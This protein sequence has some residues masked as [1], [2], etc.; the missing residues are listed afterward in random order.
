M[1]EKSLVAVVAGARPNFMKIAPLIKE[2]KNKQINYK[3]IH[4]GQHYDFAMSKVFFQDLEIDDPDIFLN[5]GS[6]SHAVQTAKIMIA[7]EKW[8]IQNNPIL[9]IVVGDVNSTIACAL[10]AKKLFIKV[11]HIESGLRSFDF[12]MPEEINRILTDH[13]S[14]FLFITEKSA[15]NNLLKEGIDKKKIHFTG[16]IMIDSLT[17]NLNKARNLK[18]YKK[19][20]LIKNEFALVTLHRPSNVDNIENLK[21]I[22]KILKYIS[23]Q[24]RVIFPMHPRTRKSFNK[25]K[26]DEDFNK[27]ELIIIE[28]LGYLDFLNLMINSK[29]ILTDSG[30][31]QE[32]A[33]ALKIPI[34]TLRENTERPITIEK[35]TN[36]IVGRDFEK[37]KIFLNQILTDK[38]KKGE[39]IERWDGKAAK[40]IVEIL[41]TTLEEL[42]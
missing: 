15:E 26:L 25:L 18:S 7:F 40:R 41:I 20:N 23:R 10:T 2:F 12:N 30:G 31:I 27:N 39:S 6:A 11:A 35:G 5:V 29:L 9:V 36:E 13:L 3:L 28:P 32:E 37:I 16:N 1:S 38:Y 22:I 34:L 17:F 33:S 24:I 19:F 14:D 42:S 4:T 21:E 8:L